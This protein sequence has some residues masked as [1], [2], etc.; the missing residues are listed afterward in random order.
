MLSGHVDTESNYFL[1]SRLNY[2]RQ[3]IYCPATS[4]SC[5]EPLAG[6]SGA[7]QHS[8][9]DIL[10]VYFEYGPLACSLVNM[11][12]FVPRF[13]SLAAAAQT[14][15]EQVGGQTVTAEQAAAA[16][17]SAQEE[18]AGRA[19]Q[20]KT[21]G[22]ATSCA[23][24]PQPSP[25]P[26]I[27]ATESLTRLI[28]RSLAWFEA[29]CARVLAETAQ[30][31]APA[32]LQAQPPPAVNLRACNLQVFHKTLSKAQLVKAAPGRVHEVVRTREMAHEGLYDSRDA[33]LEC[34][35]CQISSWTHQPSDWC[36]HLVELSQPHELK[37][38][39]LAY[40]VPVHDETSAA[41]KATGGGGANLL[42]RYAALSSRAA[43]NSAVLLA[44]RTPQT[45]AAE[46]PAD[47]S[48]ESSSSSSS[49][50]TESS[51]KSRASP[52][53]AAGGPEA[54]AQAQQQP[55]DEEAK[56]SQSDSSEGDADGELQQRQK[57][58]P[59][60][61]SRCEHLMQ[62][63]LSI[64]E[65]TNKRL[66]QHELELQQLSSDELNDSPIGQLTYRLFAPCQLVNSSSC[67]AINPVNSS[68]PLARRGSVDLNGAGLSSENARPS[69]TL[70]SAA[71]STC[72]LSAP[73][74][75]GG[76]TE[77][78][79]VSFGAFFPTLSTHNLLD[80]QPAGAALNTTAPSRHAGY[81]LQPAAGSR[82][83]TNEFEPID[84][85]RRR[86]EIYVTTNSMKVIAGETLT[87]NLND[88]LSCLS[89]AIEQTVVR[90]SFAQ[91]APTT[92]VSVYV[93]YA[94]IGELPGELLERQRSQV[95]LAQIA[96]ELDAEAC[97][98]DEQQV[99]APVFDDNFEVEARRQVETP[100]KQATGGEADRETPTK[101]TATASSGGAADE[102]SGSIRIERHATH[103]S[104]LAL[105]NSAYER[106]VA[107]PTQPDNHLTNYLEPVE[108]VQGSSECLWLDESELIEAQQK[109]LLSKKRK[110]AKE[111]RPAE[112]GR[113]QRRN[114]DSQCSLI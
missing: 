100:A 66:R 34:A 18:A 102:E 68:S 87:V 104:T 23:P 52:E 103:D 25:T 111:K 21:G 30:E 82:Y 10:R 5:R 43:V 110:F 61:E 58:K 3:K 81:N 11:I 83:T 39:R 113:Q 112:R 8:L 4:W 9:I 31:A 91:S 114:K 26:K 37:F 96:E 19:E 67:F 107:L 71:E 14:Q 12:D 13:Y 73:S 53:L 64:V 76:G 33:P 24:P 15:Q 6:S 41:G 105:Y 94:A 70:L 69:Q 2:A 77:P 84:A 72:E 28:R 108:M 57:R 106:T 95:R 42:E 80:R 109:R 1:D 85:I 22:D 29:E 89:T 60:R 7:E 92:W 49:S 101:A 20:S 54:A 51:S 90:A 45:G 62:F 46:S 59:E 93:L 40:V 48:S 99:E 32:Q 50:W 74:A 98:A 27:A 16:A 35:E 86:M 78:Q 47:S 88:S 63:A 55:E 38:V 97:A 56:D 36:E 75:G 44:S 65:Q 17:A 79:T